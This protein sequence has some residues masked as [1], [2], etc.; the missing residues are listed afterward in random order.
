VDGDSIVH[1]AGPFESV[2]RKG[3]Q[4]RTHVVSRLQ[5][6]KLVGTTTANYQVTGPDSVTQLDFE[7]TRKQ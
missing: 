5:G 3:V 6:D 7:G 4:L 1:E 2:L